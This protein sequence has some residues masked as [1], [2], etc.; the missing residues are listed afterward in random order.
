M[1]TQHSALDY[2]FET[3]KSS[4]SMF[5]NDFWLNVFEAILFPIF[6]DLKYPGKR[7]LNRDDLA[8]WLSTT[9]IKALRQTVELYTFYYDRLADLLVGVLNL[10]ALCIMNGEE[11]LTRVGCS[12]LQGLCENLANK[13]D[14]A[15]WA[16]VGHILADLFRQTSPVQAVS[17]APG[18]GITQSTLGGAV[19]P[20]E[21]DVQREAMEIER[22]GELCEVQLILL[23]TVNEMFMRK[24]SIAQCIG[25]NELFLLTDATARSYRHAQQFNRS[26]QS[27]ESNPGIL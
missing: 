26:V 3:L 7:F 19:L 9:L 12:S 22:C 10:L 21:E 27:V 1:L 17:A 11:S 14:A 23:D 24:T 2:L 6:N 20:S 25:L 4:G 15:A 13:M 5:P 8:V 16:S 18:D